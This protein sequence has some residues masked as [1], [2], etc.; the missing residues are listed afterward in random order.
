VTAVTEGIHLDSVERLATMSAAE[1]D[2][3]PYGFLIL[4]RSGTVLLYNRYESRMSRL[5]PGRVVGKNWFREVAPCT[6][7]EAFQGRF[8]ALVDSPTA[9]VERFSF[10]FHFLHGA[11]DVTVQLTRAPGDADR[12]FM[13]VVRRSV[14]GAEVDLPRAAALN[15]HIGAI[16]GPA[17]VALPLPAR[18]I[19]VLMDRVGLAE[20]HAIGDALGHSIASAAERDAALVGEESIPHAPPLL[21]SGVLD[22]SLASAGFGRIAI[23]LSAR[24]TTGAIG[25]VLRAPSV[26]S[27]KGLIAFYEGLLA[28][29]IGRAIGEPM[30]VRSLDMDEATTV[31]W[32]LA[33]VPS[34]SRGLLDD[35]GRVE[36]DIVSRRLGVF[37]DEP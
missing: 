3:L 18:T 11:Q 26:T 15:E 2:D 10:R 20:A 33:A 36:A 19:G 9:L 14:G 6:R 5:P 22:A 27:S 8:H 16:V 35:A 7:V 1:V 21:R 32:L 4:D 28:S 37:V 24:E 31:P 25:I 23:D 17:G 29:L 13:T 30:V 12:I 34:A